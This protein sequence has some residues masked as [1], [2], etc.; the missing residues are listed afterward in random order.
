MHFLSCGLFF[1]GTAFGF[2]SFL[3]SDSP[4]KKVVFLFSLKEKED[5]GTLFPS[6]L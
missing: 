1:E 2:D 3:S 6:F 4:P 5:P